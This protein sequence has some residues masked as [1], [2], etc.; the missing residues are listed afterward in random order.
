MSIVG[1]YYL[2][3]ADYACRN[4]FLPPYRGVRYHLSEFGIRNRP[5]NARELYNLRH[6]S[7]RVTVERAIGAL[8]NRFRI[9][10][11]KPFR[12]CKT[13]VKL[14]LA[15]AILRN[16]ILGFG[17]DVVVPIDEGFTGSPPEEDDMLPADLAQDYI[18]MFATRD[19][20]CNAMWEGRGTSRV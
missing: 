18:G 13:Q 9:L 2:V 10:D 17:I 4:G 11:N 15:C 14:V 12:K 7:L 16:W 5:N 6:S 1:K 20:I 8:K 19:S 3:D